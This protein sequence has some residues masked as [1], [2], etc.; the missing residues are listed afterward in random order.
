MWYRGMRRTFDRLTL[1]LRGDHQMFNAALALCAVEL[2][3]EAGFTLGEAAVRQGLATVQWPG[4][5]ELIQRPGKPLILL[6]GAHNPAGVK[7]LAEYLGTHFLHK[8]RILIFG[9]MKDKAFGEMLPE[10]LPLVGKVILTRPE[11]DRAAL[12]D[13]VA[14]YAPGA[15]ITS[16]LKEALAEGF[17][18]AR[19]NDL[20]VVTG[21]F[22]TVGEAR[23]LLDE[24]R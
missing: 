5:L 14:P 24:E 8:R 15:L 2:L 22:Y 11:V 12:P 3:N 10:L 6:D 1:G 17:K 20:L 23:K 19:E 21:S 7:T 9:V 18:I 4:R 16:S 13:E